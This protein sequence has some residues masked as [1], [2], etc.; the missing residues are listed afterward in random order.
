M[1]L[2]CLNVWCGK[3]HD[4]LVEFLKENSDADI[5]CFQELLLA[6]SS[7][8]FV[9]EF[10]PGLL[11]ELKNVLTGFRSFFVEANDNFGQAIFVRKKNYA[12]FGADI[13]LEGKEIVKFPETDLR[14][15]V[16]SC[17]IGNLTVFNFHGFSTWP[18]IDTPERI[19]QSEKLLEYISK[20]EGRKIL[21]GDFNVWQDTKSVAMIEARMRNLVRE[22]GVETTRVAKY[23]P[24]DRISDY[25][26]VSKEV[27]VKSFEIPD[28]IVSD[29]LPLILEFE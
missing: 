11:N 19:R 8:Q 17:C 23:S 1:K 26:F 13:I 29:H 18:K 2:V 5:F 10:R 12:E 15:I 14:R 20:F 24:D 16:Q 6:K 22:I 4:P 28:V 27:K 25:A 21:C 3:L 9:S 7:M